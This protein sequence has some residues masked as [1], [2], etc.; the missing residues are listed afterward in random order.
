MILDIIQA[1][2]SLWDTAHILRGEP[3][4]PRTAWVRAYREALLAGQT[5]AIITALEAEGHDPT[6]TATQ[7]RAVWRTVGDD[8]RNRP[9]MRYDEYLAHGWPIGMGAVEGAYEH[10]VKDRMEPSGM[11]WTQAGAQAG[12]RL[13]G[14]AA[15]RAVGG[16]L[17][18]SST[19]TTSPGLWPL[20]SCAGVGRSPSA[21]EG[22]LINR[23]STNSGHTQIISR[24]GQEGRLHPP[25]AER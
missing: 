7:R 14:G 6:C 3:H 1:T 10:V 8:R 22:C 24:T 9:Y 19:P 13:A 15:Q 18:V 17:A 2:E 12:D 4:P 21:G 11:R 16:L 20:D 25:R 5:D 23:L